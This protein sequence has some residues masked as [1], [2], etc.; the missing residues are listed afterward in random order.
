[1]S[2]MLFGKLPAHGDFVARGLDPDSRDALDIWLSAEMAGARA[3]FPSD[4]E[5]RYDHAPPWRFAVED[6]AG[7]VCGTIAPSADQAGR[8]FP[9]LVARVA[10]AA[11]AVPGLAAACEQALAETFAGGWNAD[12]LQERLLTLG[13]E[14]EEVP[15]RQGWW[16]VHGAAEAPRLAG[17]RPEGLLA[18]M[19]ADKEP[20]E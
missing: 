9:L 12:R 14:A 1:M 15:P 4:F 2:A 17:D 20:A 13:A 18:A 19:L 10:D 8:R 5:Q 7:W 6:E 16:T 3:T 11:D